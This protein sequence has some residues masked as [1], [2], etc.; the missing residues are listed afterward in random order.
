MLSRAADA[1]NLGGPMIAK[2]VCRFASNTASKF[3]RSQT[4]SGGGSYCDLRYS[5]KGK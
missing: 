3:G 1:E 5:A 2:T 4:I